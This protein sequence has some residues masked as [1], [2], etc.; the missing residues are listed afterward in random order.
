MKDGAIM[1]ESNAQKIERE[2]I[3]PGTIKYQAPKLSHK[4]IDCRGL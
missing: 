1:R 2:Q 3:P 4:I